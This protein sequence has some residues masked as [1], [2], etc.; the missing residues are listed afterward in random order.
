MQGEVFSLDQVAAICGWD[1]YQIKEWI[2]KQELHASG[3]LNHSEP[4]ISAVDL[5]SFLFHRKQDVPAG[6]RQ[7]SRRVLIAEDDE[8]MARSLHRVLTKA[9]FQTERAGDG[10]KVGSM[11]A[12]FSPALLILDINMPETNGLEVLA[13]LRGEKRFDHIR[14]L[15][16]SAAPRNQLQAARELGADEVLEKPFENEE[17]LSAVRRLSSV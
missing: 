1:I 3:T 13:Y 10:F 2:E 16:V 7:Y 11:L 15:V 12:G 5:L 14:V 6:L 17:F 9:G 4:V 8:P